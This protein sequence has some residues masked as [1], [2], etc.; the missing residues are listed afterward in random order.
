LLKDKTGRIK[1]NPGTIQGQYRNE[2]ET[3]IITLRAHGK[4]GDAI[5]CKV[6]PD[7]CE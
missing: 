1:E 2:P 3:A 6:D 4:I 5:S 7:I